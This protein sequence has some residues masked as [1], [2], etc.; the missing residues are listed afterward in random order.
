MKKVL[1]LILA[2]AM[3]FSLVS[4]VSAANEGY[5]FTAGSYTFGKRGAIDSFD[6]GVYTG[7]NTL[8][9]TVGDYDDEANGTENVAYIVLDIATRITAPAGYVTLQFDEEK[10]TPVYCDG[11]GMYPVT[12]A[13]DCLLWDFTNNAQPVEDETKFSGNKLLLTW[14][15]KNGDGNNGTIAMIPFALNTGVTTDD[16]DSTTFTLVASSDAFITDNKLDFGGAGIQ[17]MTAAKFDANENTVFTYP[18]SD[19][20]PGPVGPV[21]AWT[22]ADNNASATVVYDAAVTGTPIIAVYDANGTMIGLDTGDDVT[23]ATSFTV[24]TSYTGTAAKAKVFVWTGY[25]STNVAATGAK[26]WTAAN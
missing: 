3:L 13:A 11:Y 1:S 26:V 19:K 7:T 16:F 6:A 5:S 14:N 23:G 22:V 20:V 15:A 18:N 10:V 21:E 9:A 25:G 17:D 24:S 2:C 8:F 4:V 12:D